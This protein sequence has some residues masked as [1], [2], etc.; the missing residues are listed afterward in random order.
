MANVDNKVVQMDFKNQ[1]F[2]KNI[3]ESQKSL[4]KLKEA[5]NFKDAGKDTKKVEE[6]LHNMVPQSVQ[7][8]IQKIADRFST[9][10]IAAMEVITRITSGLIDVGMTA[11]NALVLKPI[12]D[13]MQE[14]ETQI[15]AVQTIMANTSHKGTTMN[16]IMSALDE[17]NTY[18]DLT[19]YNFSEMTRNVGT[20]TAAGIDLDRAVPAIK[21]IANVAAMSGS[22]SQQASTAMYQ[23]SQALSSGT[24]KLQ[25]WNSVVNAGMGGEVM[26]N[27]LKE[28]ARNHGIAVD[29]I[30]EKQGSFRE[31]LST[32]WATAEILTETLMKF[33][34]DLSAEQLKQ[35]G[36]AEDQIAG[37]MELAE[38]ANDAATKVKTFTQ[39]IDTLAEGL[40]SGW[41]QT[42]RLILGDF[43]EAKELWTGVS[44]VLG[45]M[46]NASADARN[47]MVKGWR[48]GG[49]RAMAIEGLANIFHAFMGIINQFK[50]AWRDIFPP[51]TTKTLLE[52][53][54]RFRDFT[55]G[56]KMTE[57]QL[58]PLATILRGIFAALDIG[59]MFI[60]ALWYGFKQLVDIFS[61]VGDG[62]LSLTTRFYELIFNLR[63][64]IKSTDAFRK[65]VDAII[66]VIKRVITFITP[67]TRA[68][69]NFFKS[70]YLAIREWLPGA[71]EQVR[72]FA[73]AVRKRFESFRTFIDPIIQRFKTF[74]RA[75]KDAFEGFKGVDTSGFDN[76]MDKMSAKLEPLR[77]IGDAFTKLLGSLWR[78]IQR[79]MPIF[80]K[81]GTLI[82]NTFSDIIN[83]ISG[84]LDGLS[85]TGL[86]EIINMILG[87]GILVGLNKLVKGFN[88]FTKD[89][90]GMLE[91]ITGILDG[92]KGS[93]EAWQTSIKASALQKIAIALGILTLSLVVLSG[94]DAKKLTISLT[95]MGVLMAEIFGS[96]AIFSK[97]MGPRNFS[98][99]T[100]LGVALIGMSVAV[101]ILTS[102]LKRIATIDPE[103]I[104]M[105]LLAV[106]VLLGELVLMSKLVSRRTMGLVKSGIAMIAFAGAI[107]ILAG[108]VRK[109][110]DVDADS[111]KQGLMGVGVLMLEIAI[112][113]K[114][115]KYSDVGVGAGIGILAVAAGVLVLVKAVKAFAAMDLNGMIQGLVAVGSLL[116]TLGIF[117]RITGN[118][119]GVIATAI[120]MIILGG[121]MHIFISA[122]NKFGNMDF[123][124][125]KQGLIGFA[126]ALAA[127]TLS[128]K[129][130]PKGMMTNAA[131][132]VGIAAAM[133]V[134]S[135]ALK[136]LG[137][138]SLAEIGKSLLALGVGLGIMTIAMNAMVL[139]IPGAQAMLMMTAALLVLVPVL[140]VLGSMSMVEIGKSLLVLASVFAILGVAGFVLAPIT[141][142]IV[143]LAGAVA[144]FGAGCILAGVGVLLLAT[145]FGALS[146]AGAAGSSAL[147]V[148][149]TA[150]LSLI[151]VFF[152]KLGEGIIALSVMIGG[153]L[154]AIVGM[155]TTILMAI[156]A[157]LNEALPALVELIVTFLAHLLTTLAEH[158]PAMAEAGWSILLTFLNALR[159]NLPELIAIGIDMIVA[160]ILGIAAGLPALIDAGFKLII[161]FINGLADAIEENADELFDAFVN[162]ADSMIKGLIKGL[163][164]GIEVIWN[165]AKELGK[166]ALGGIKK[167][168][169]IN[170]PS[171][172]FEY[173]GTDSGDG[174]EIG[175]NKSKNKV[176]KA[177]EE[178]G[179]AA[180]EGLSTTD[181]N[182]FS[183]LGFD[184]GMDYSSGLDLTSE[185]SFL[186]GSNVSMASLEG[187]SLSDGEGFD[188][189]S[190]LGTDYSSALSGTSDFALLSG[191]DVSTAAL[192]GLDSKSDDSFALGKKYGASFNTAIGEEATNSFAAGASIGSRAVDG[193]T[194]TGSAFELKGM[195]FGKDFSSALVKDTKVSENAGA[196]LTKSAL[197]GLTKDQ[198]KFTDAGKQAAEMYCRAFNESNNRARSA[199]V[200][201][202][203]EAVKG[204]D[205]RRSDFTSAGNYAGQGFVNGI[206]NYSTA[207]YNAGSALAANASIGA[208]KKLDVRSPS[209]VMFEVGKFFDL[210]FVNGI[211][212]FAGSV[213][214]ASIAVADTAID[215]IASAVGKIADMVESDM[216]TAPVIRPVLD[217][218]SIKSGI[219]SANTLLAGT[220]GLSLGSTAI[221]GASFAAN[222]FSNQ[223][224]GN[225]PQVINNYNDTRFEQTNNSPKALSAIEIYRRTNNLFG[226]YAS[227]GG[228]TN[229][230]G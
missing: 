52:L 75:V 29:S 10:G 130:L 74:G 132:M 134:L 54:K 18:A 22:N 214:D 57:T 64:T 159:E 136:F 111:L 195:N 79:L 81:L 59:R 167:F 168:L 142:I 205:S 34:G 143:A 149:I 89:A 186:S 86:F 189:G 230:I 165:A 19:I 35:M 88:S 92:V 199:G 192:F 114:L 83:A 32:G 6:A 101:L 120:A 44:D 43:E 215:G 129:L 112:F 184:F 135:V 221:V 67:Y 61:P 37:I 78:V 179:S 153:S 203:V 12:M 202:A 104:M 63:N 213:E 162:L 49:G 146:V 9:M 119:A 187:L 122:V 198:K 95:A 76:L 207:A 157:A 177:G 185:N 94:I 150:I 131:G 33:T 40:G 218:D 226:Q 137:S 182:A 106:G 117:S 14:Y 212:A 145:A 2:E 16:E 31:S 58:K 151:P 7:D 24:L 11:A 116:L 115:A 68:V 41:A 15:N 23:L 123:E 20:F 180:L 113:M 188:M 90:G 178:L 17:L 91:S 227:K 148:A 45:D 36:Y 222:G 193:A 141:P 217:L 5:L 97:A 204:I 47:E 171:K 126:L 223:N 72:E 4:D 66:N 25:D 93:L 39:L 96:L 155:V 77:K 161:A 105:G 175:L 210:G 166:A 121:A 50:S 191:T 138:L 99:L 82:S 124:V 8:N 216:D 103:N 164:S 197:T 1:Q 42:W 71:I 100:K 140:K 144:M 51:V 98:A 85:F 62:M 206:R 48:N 173:V 139:G 30:I 156:I 46:I 65:G 183:D 174:M 107:T 118:G 147:V 209:R 170:S 228:V 128:M 80:K 169:G 172:E 133:V 160:F 108:A 127:V 26:Q 38:T 229:A 181:S 154:E 225:L 56:L 224:G 60:S 53:T 55:E 194:S 110:A 13:G 176:G 211:N 220:N 102:A 69:Q 201:V 21:G 125:L 84:G 196:D 208:K 27:A 190:M 28:T 73:E 152:T 109:M 70:V 163:G 219:A 200:G 3:A 158:A 87:S